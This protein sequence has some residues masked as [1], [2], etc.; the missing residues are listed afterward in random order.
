MLGLLAVNI[1][2]NLT[3]YRRNQLLVVVS[4]MFLILI[5]L[6][7][8]P[9]FFF[10]S[11]SGYFDIIK[12]IFSQLSTVVYLVT[13]AMGLLWISQH[14][15]GRSLKMVF[16]KPCTP[17]VW[18]LSGLLSAAL[19]SLAL[20]AGVVIVCAAL[21][22]IWDLPFQ[23]GLLV[24]AFYD[25]LQALILLAYTT[26]LSV[27]FHPVLAILVI[28][29][30]REGTFATAKMVL[31]AGMKAL[32]EETASL[33]LSLLKGTL[34]ALYML[35]PMFHPFPE[36]F[37]EIASSFRLDDARWGS[38]GLTLLYALTISA[39]FYLLSV[40]FLKRQRHV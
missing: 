15:S 18:L 32:G 23:W 8:V 19:V 28:F 9:A 6:S 20:Y 33:G 14:R 12:M 30:F 1:R 27:I 21:F 4:V 7:T 16:T 11:S 36:E 13:A 26:L 2:N 35:T 24:V 39:F 29:L 38:L 34:D 40:F 5:G 25:F 10:L 3:F 22:M 37:S 31:V 17:E